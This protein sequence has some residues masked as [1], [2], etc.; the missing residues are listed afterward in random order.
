MLFC[1]PKR[2]VSCIIYNIKFETPAFITQIL[3][4]AKFTLLEDTEINMA[5]FCESAV[6]QLC[7][8]YEAQ[9]INLKALLPVYA[10]GYQ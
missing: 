6:Q 9:A 2:S 7:R 1:K 5:L 8:R 10:S 4:S 3:P